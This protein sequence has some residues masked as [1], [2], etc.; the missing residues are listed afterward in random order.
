MEFNKEQVEVL[1]DPVN[2]TE[3]FG[4]VK[5]KD[6]KFYDPDDPKEDRRHLEDIYRDPHPR[7]IILSSRQV[8]K[9]ETVVRNML[10]KAFT[11]PHVT[12][13][14]AS[15]RLDQTYRFSNDRLRAGLKQSKGNGVLMNSL[16]KDSTK[17]MTFHNHHQMY[18]GSTYGEAD[19]LRGITADYL[20]FDEFQ[21]ME[22]EGIA[23]LLET[24]SHS[25]ITTDVE[26]N[27]EITTLRGKVL[28]TGT[29]KNTGSLYEQY[30]ELSDQRYWDTE[31]KEW[32]PQKDPSKCL[33]RGY[34]M[35]QEMMPWITDQEIEYKR[36]TYSE[37]KFINEVKGEFYSGL[38]KPLQWSDIEPNL[39]Y[40]TSLYRKLPITREAYMGIDWGGGQSAFTV[41]T[42][43]APNPETDKL[44]MVYVEKFEEKHI[45]DQIRKINQLMEDFNVTGVVADLGFGQ[46]QIQMLQEKWG[47]MVQSCYYT[48]GSKNPE[49][50]NESEDGMK[51]TVDRSNQLFKVFD[52]FKGE[53]I[54]IPYS[55][56]D[57]LKEIFQHY[58]CVEAE[59]VAPSS[60]RTGYTKVIKPNSKNDDAL[61]SLNYAHIAYQIGS[62]KV[63]YTEGET[64]EF[65]PENDLLGMMGLGGFGNSF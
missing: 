57:A 5:G 24:L 25:E 47:N 17:H 18:F 28:I 21:D 55:N 62:Q 16:D 56:P 46:A 44:E 61:H 51:L 54:E 2:F 64:R 38:A 53:E 35:S 8:E 14:Y 30:W 48:A 10:H 6:F 7:K 29:P 33:F 23:T 43:L 3:T 1:K 31:K 40:A 9:T 36:Q 49:D 34:H 58:T 4:T 50:I 19:S 22:E 11:V 15:P 60:G 12:Q 27:G 52:L 26:I 63:D 42:I 39:K 65:T 45:P 59:P 41:V 32:I 20:Y 37:Q 13:V